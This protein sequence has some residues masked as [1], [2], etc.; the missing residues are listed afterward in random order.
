ML[1]EQLRCFLGIPLESKTGMLDTDSELEMF[2]I[3]N[4]SRWCPK[5]TY[6]PIGG[7]CAEQ[8][9]V[10]THGEK[11]KIAS[12]LAGSSAQL[13]RHLLLGLPAG[14]DGADA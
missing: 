4:R 7:R 8:K 14:A 1:L 3:I 12:F 9:V 11:K 6:E 2:D 5:R 10:V 13:F